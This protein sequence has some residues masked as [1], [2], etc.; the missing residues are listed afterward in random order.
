MRKL[1][2][3]FTSFIALLMVI[4]AAGYGTLHTQYAPKLVNFVF[5]QVLDKPIAVREV[6]Y[7]YQQARHITFEGVLVKNPQT[8]QS[9]LIRKVDIWLDN[10]LWKDS[11]LQID[12][13]LM[14]GIKLQSG[15]PKLAILPHINIKQLAISSIDFADQGW[16]VRDMTM[17]VKHPQYRPS[18]IFPFYGQIQLSADQIYWQG[19]ALDKVFIDG[20]ISHSN[21]I[22]YDMRFNWRHGKFQAQATKGSD[23]HVW[24]LPQVS[25]AG[26][27]LQQHNL[28]AIHSDVLAWF[29]HI[30]MDIDQLDISDSSLEVND[31]TAN[32]LLI[33]AR[34]VHLP[35]KLWQ[36]QDASIN[37]SADSMSAMGQS[38]KSPNLTLNL[39]PQSAYVQNL[40]LE[41]LQGD[42]HLQGKFKPDSADIK[43]LNINNIKWIP[44]QESK[45]LVLAYFNQLHT[46]NAQ[47]LTINNVQV[48]D[49]TQTPAIQTSGMSI[50]GDQLELKRDGRWGLWDGKLSISA[51][52]ATYDK[53]TSR[54]LLL[55]MHSKDGHFWLEKLFVPL[56]DGLIKASGDMDYAKTSQPWNLSVEASGIP[57]RF[58]TRVFNLP[59]HLDGI[60]DF[61]VKGEGLYGDQL[62]FNH[63]VTGKLEA[64]ISQ[65]TSSDDFEALWL[66]NQGIELDPSEDPHPVDKPKQPTQTKQAVSIGN[67]HLNADRGRVALKPF[68]IKGKD[69]TAYLGGNYDF[70]F[71]EKGNVQY[72][73][74]GK[75]KCKALIF[76]LLGDNSAITMEDNCQ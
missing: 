64:T 45:D 53:V 13:V 67:I 14:E 60:T 23:E 58:F 56:D 22:I 39:Q 43:L 75:G 12:N 16:V 63:S 50:D 17:Q 37:L 38:I 18:K 72:K 49:L 55:N 6:S 29:N 35:F 76:N 36:Q 41:V 40:S 15:W 32:N 4:L 3:I 30:A 73:L 8:H 27:R 7:S 59:L 48:I 33:N 65:A 9:I 34:H 20:D 70:L 11:K 5:S 28:E 68:S 61:T 42:I 10:P 31:F 71:P 51:S 62:I 1:L 44:S 66:R 25:I 21:T 46:L 24:Q 57:L 26:L 47:S 74:E 54:N 69:F 2:I 52:S 19:E